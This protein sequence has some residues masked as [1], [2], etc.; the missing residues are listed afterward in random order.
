MD[1]LSE[2]LEFSVITDGLEAYLL[3]FLL[4]M[5]L[6]TEETA[7]ERSDTHDTHRLTD[8][9]ASTDQADRTRPWTRTVNGEWRCS[10]MQGGP[11]E[12]GNKGK[13]QRHGGKYPKE[14]QQQRG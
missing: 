1:P 6:L 7:L 4:C 3:F 8:T 2:K 14:T 13:I 5:G 12:S 9:Q 11:S 10:E